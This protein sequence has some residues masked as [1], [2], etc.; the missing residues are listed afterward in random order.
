MS[1]IAFQIKQNQIKIISNP[2]AI[3]I[4]RTLAHALLSK[5]NKIKEKQTAIHPQIRP[6][7]KPNNILI[8]ESWSIYPAEEHKCNKM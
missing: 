3:S 8:I 6:S 4:I 5:S 2:L 1:Y 7:T